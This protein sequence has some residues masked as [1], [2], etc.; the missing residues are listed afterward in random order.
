[1]LQKV[2]G[3]ALI[4]K[5]QSILLME[6]DFNTT[7][8]I[9]YGQRMLDVVRKYKLR[10]EEICSKKNCLTDDGTLVNV[11]FYDIVSQTRLPA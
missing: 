11:P 10:R 4:T 1:M 6:A 7:N 3:C 5:L 9:F 8:K 2:F